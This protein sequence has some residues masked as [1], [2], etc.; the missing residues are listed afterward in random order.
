[1]NKNLM[2]KN[3]KKVKQFF[4]DR[5]FFIPNLVT[6]ISICL[7]MHAIYLIFH[8]SI[9][10]SILCICAAAFVDGIDGR[11]ARY[12]NSASEFGKT[13]DSLADFLSFSISPAL[14]IYFYKLNGW[15]SFGWSCCIFFVLCMAF[16]LARFSSDLSDSE[17]FTGVPAP[18]AG[19]L[20]FLPV[21]IE[22]VFQTQLPPLFFAITLLLVAFGMIGR[23]K[24]I[25]L[26]KIK[27]KPGMSHIVFGVCAFMIVMSITYIWLTAFIIALIYVSHLLYAFTKYEKV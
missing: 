6:S 25:A 4:R 9:E 21:V 10:Y 3:T 13:I 8:K 27:I 12:L 5:I 19:L 7:G 16:R 24:T 14:V 26:N 18:A 22:K 1:M 2:Q 20:A 17:A 11:I 15:I 23:F